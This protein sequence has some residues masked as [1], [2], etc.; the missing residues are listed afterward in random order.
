MRSAWF[1]LLTVAIITADP[2][3]AQNSNNNFLEC[4]RQV[5]AVEFPRPSGDHLR[6]WRFNGEAQHMAFMNCVARKAKLAP[7][8]AVA[9]KKPQ[10][11]SQ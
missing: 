7:T 2:A 8:N 5:G 10:R 1:G 6:Q 3:Q 11:P 9:A 4:A